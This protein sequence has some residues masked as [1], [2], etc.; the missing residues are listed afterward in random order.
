M[1][2]TKKKKIAFVGQPEYFGFVYE[3]GIKGFEIRGYDY[4]FDMKEE[5][6]KDLADYDADY[7]IFFRGEFVPESVLEKLRGVKIALSSEP[8]PRKIDGKWEYTKDSLKRYFDFRKR[9][10][11]K[12]YDY[13]FHYDASSMEL[14]KKDGLGLS[15]EFVFP[16]SRKIYKNLNSKKVRDI[17]FLGRST[18][19]REGYFGALKH[20]YNFL[21]I[22]HGIYG[23]KLF[24]KLTNE[25]T[26]NFNIHAEDE[27]SW[28]PRL[29]ILLASGAFVISEKITP[30]RYIKPGRD[31]I[32]IKNPS[33]AMNVVEYYLKNDKKRERIITNAE[34]T[35][36]KYFDSDKIFP[37]FLNK[38]ENGQY[39]RFSPK[40]KGDLAIRIAGRMVK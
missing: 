40:A 29:Q 2:E 9:I 11:S 12:K 31:F 33:E 25:S 8:F 39:P 10:R 6:F 38:I 37:E 16:V 32:E 3:G 36:N 23:G 7:N 30:N 1:P 24:N 13:V 4:N 18:A 27:I 35:I 34:K 28:E 21:H 26:I 14:F 20:Y 19:H 15:G 17:F 22:A 5:E